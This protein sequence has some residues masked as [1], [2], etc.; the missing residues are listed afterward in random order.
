[1]LFS[2]SLTGVGQAEISGGFG[3]DFRSGRSRLHFS[4]Y[5][6]SIWILKPTA[7]FNCGP[8]IIKKE[9]SENGPSWTSCKSV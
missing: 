2:R 6:F 8:V 3:F 4:N 1:M 7:G 5:T 9:Y